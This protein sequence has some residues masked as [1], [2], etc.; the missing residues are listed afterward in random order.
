MSVFNDSMAYE[1]AV[2]I[3][4]AALQG[5]V[6][7]L[8]GPSAHSPGNVKVDSDYLNQVITSIAGNLT[9]K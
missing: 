8:Q 1:R 3:V 4:V 2:S 7:K 5:G 6:L 9:E